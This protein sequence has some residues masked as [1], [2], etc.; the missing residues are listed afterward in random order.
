MNKFQP[1]FRCPIC[2]SELIANYNNTSSIDG[3]F[4]STYLM[5]CVNS[6]CIWHR[7]SE[8]SEMFLEDTQGKSMR[9]ILAEWRRRQYEAIV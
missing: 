2:D 3:I 8:V 1:P 4:F 5:H 6:N 9:F 7:E